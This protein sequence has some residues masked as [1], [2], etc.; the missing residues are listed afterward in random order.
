MLSKILQYQMS[1]Y[2]KEKIQSLIKGWIY[3]LFSAGHFPLFVQIA[4]RDMNN[5]TLKD[6]HLYQIWPVDL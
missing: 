5:P 2:I 1:V 4:I 3:P 6:A